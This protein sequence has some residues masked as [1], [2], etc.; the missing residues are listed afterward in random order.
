MASAMW[1]VTHDMWH[2]THYMLHVTR[3]GGWRFSQNFSSL[4]LTVWERQCFEDW[5]ENY[6]W[7]TELNGYTG[8]VKYLN[9][10]YTLHEMNPQITTEIKST[11]TNKVNLPWIQKVRNIHIYLVESLTVSVL[12]S[13]ALVMTLARGTNC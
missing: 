8:S 5:E 11:S 4:A 2:M 7:L 1:H 9:N 3:G 6:D 10:N 12:L 13:Q